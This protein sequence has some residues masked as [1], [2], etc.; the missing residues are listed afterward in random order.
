MSSSFIPKPFTLSV[1]DAALDDLRNRLELT[2][3]PSE[4]SGAGSS[5]GTPLD[6]ISRLVS[7]WKNG[8][9]WRKREAEINEL[10]MFTGPVEV[11]GFGS[12]DIHFVHQKSTNE[13]A[14]P[15]LFSH[16]CEPTFALTSARTPKLTPHIRTGP[17]HFLEIE[18]I[19]PLLTNA[20]GEHPSFHVVAPSLPGFGFSEYPTKT[21]FGLVQYAEVSG[22]TA[23]LCTNPELTSMLGL[24]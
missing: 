18:K 11:D 23:A 3:L 22:G 21:G 5:R 24:S 1:S 9:D 16:G 8:H 13:R 7:R 2:R 19:L 15:L 17:G 12:L 6:T 14:I 10:P 4:L 20:S